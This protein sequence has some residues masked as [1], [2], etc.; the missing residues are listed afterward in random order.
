MEDEHSKF[1]WE[2]VENFRRTLELGGII[3]EQCAD[4]LESTKKEWTKIFQEVAELSGKETV[5][6]ISIGD[7]EDISTH[8]VKDLKKLI[9]SLNYPDIKILEEFLLRSN[10][11]FLYSEFES[12]FFKCLKFLCLEFP[13]ILN[14][15][16][17]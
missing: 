14:K 17:I 10:T 1:A 4:H 3:K 8:K 11:L 6:L 13:S 9:H 12:Y 7:P 5:A 15:K 16:V 2:M